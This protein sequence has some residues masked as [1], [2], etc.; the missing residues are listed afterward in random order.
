[1]DYG[2]EEFEGGLGRTRYGNPRFYKL[3]ESLAELHD[4]KSH[5]YASN[6]NPSGNYHFAGQVAALFSHSPEDAGFAGRIAE[7]VYRLSNLESGNKEPKN[8][9][10]ED[11]ERDI[12]VITLLWMADRAARRERPNRLEDELFDLIKLMPDSQQDKL[13]KFVA[14]L[15][16]IRA[17]V[18]NNREEAS[19]RAADIAYAEP[20]NQGQGA[21]ASYEQQALETMKQMAR[22]MNRFLEI[23]PP[24][25]TGIL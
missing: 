16:A 5:D 10:I 7:K 14:E 12:C 21:V 13:V 18:R 4:R 24:A 25:R 2:T 17:N 11:T 6:D 8:E 20:A 1:M 9:S 23:K 22:I 3:L 15:R 19:E